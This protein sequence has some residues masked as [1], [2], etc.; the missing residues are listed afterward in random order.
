MSDEYDGIIE[1]PSLDELYHHG[2]KGQKWGIRK[3][4]P[5]L[6]LA[7]RRIRTGSASSRISKYTRNPRKRKGYSSK[8]YQKYKSRGIS[9]AKAVEYAKRD[10]KKKIA[11]VAIG[12]AALTIGVLAA[13]KHNIKIQ[14]AKRLANQ[15]GDTKALERQ[16]KEKVK[17][18]ANAWKDYKFDNVDHYE[19]AKKGA[20]LQKYQE[21]VRNAHGKQE[22]VDLKKIKVNGNDVKKYAYNQQRLLNEATARAN[23]KKLKNRAKRWWNGA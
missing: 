13:R 7:R 1:K 21:A 15:T 20:Y 17:K 23:S 9:H 6:G 16:L 22:T 19:T 11:A 5:T 12:A 8:D 2:V 3:Q 10:R 18:Q 4:R 14:E